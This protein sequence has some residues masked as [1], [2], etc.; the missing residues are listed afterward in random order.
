MTNVDTRAAGDLDPS[1]ILLGVNNGPGLYRAPVGTPGPTDLQSPWDSPWEPIGYISS[2]G[3]TV[4]SSTTSDSLT[5]WQSTAPVKTMITGK[6]I[7]AHFIMWQT[8]PETLAMYFDM[9]P[10][11][12]DIV[13]GAVEFD[14]RSDVGG[15]LYA[16]GVDILDAGIVTRLT[17]GRAQLSATGDAVFQR[18]AAIAWDVTLS[19]LDDNGV[20]AHLISG[21][22]VPPAGQTQARR[23]SSEAAA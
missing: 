18:G 23:S 5:P 4:S 12:P 1:Q 19:A 8:N 3:V 9:P 15:I 7:T 2:D 13:S 17:F 22:E 11:T 20:L 21:P 14:I 16:I 10:V 6:E